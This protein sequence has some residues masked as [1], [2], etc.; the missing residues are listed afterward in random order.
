M[1]TGWRLNSLIYI[2]ILIVA[3]AVF[4]YLFSR[5]QEPT[6]IPLS[7]AIA[8]SQENKIEKILIEDTSLLIT[9]TDGVEMRTFKESNASIY[10]VEGFNLEGIVIEVEGS[11]GFN[12]GGLFINFLPLLLFGGLL[13]F[14]FRSARGA[15]SQALSFGRSRARLS[16]PDKPAVTFDDV[17]GVDE[18]KQE[19]YEVVE[20]LKSREKF[21]SLGARIPK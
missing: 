2:A 20:F 4:S 8:M 1:K 9:T 3:I 5:S 21:Q 7:E 6:E 19:L 11:S 10:D 16:P 15:N 14:L 13:F 18:A 17:A 12:W